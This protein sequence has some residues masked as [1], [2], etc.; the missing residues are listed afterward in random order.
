MH[1]T[2]HNKGWRSVAGILLFVCAA[3]VATQAQTGFTPGGTTISN[4]ASSTYSDGTDSYATSSNTVT[5]TV[6]NISGLTIT[7]DG[8]SNPAAVLGQTG[9][10][11]IFTVTNSGN[12]INQVRFGAGGASVVRT[13]PGAVTAAVIDVD[14]SNTINA[15]DTDIFGNASAVNSADVAQ[16]ATIKVIVRVSV[17]ANAAAGSVI[18]VQLGDASTGGPSYDNQVADS[19]AN[20]VRT[21]TAGSNPAEEARGDIS[22]TVQNDALL[23]LTLTAPAGPVAVGSDITYSWVLTNDGLRT[24]AAQTLGGN[25]GVFIVAPIPGRTALK[26]GQSFPAGTLYTTDPLTTAPLSATWTTTAP[27]D[28][29][30]VTRVALYAGASLAAGASSSS[31]SLLVTVQTGISVVLPI[32]EIGDAFAM[33]YVAAPITDQSGDA[34]ANAG[35]GNADFTQGDAIGS[36]DGDG[37]QQATAL[38]AVGGVLLGPSGQ[39]G[40][41]GPTDTNDDYTNRSVNT[42]IA[43]VAPGGSTTAAGTVVFTNTVQ[44]TGQANDTY[45]LT[46][47]SVPAGFTVEVS[48]NG[49]GTDYVTVSGGGSTT[50]AV[51]YGSTATILVRITAPSGNT[52]LTAYPTVIHAASLNTPATTNDTVD[53]L[54]TGY[55][56]L[57]KSQ[58]VANATGR[59]GATDPV[60]GATIAYVVGFDNVTSSGGTN[61]S[62]ISASSIVL[63]DPVPANTDFKAGSATS[64]PPAG[65]TVATTYSND[66]GAT[67]T[68]TPVSG[69]GSAPAG[70]DRTVTHVRFTLT[71]SMGPADIAG[72]AGFTV[73]IR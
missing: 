54:Y 60:P 65:I 37:V 38:S 16:G 29:T 69:A 13:G 72:D 68:Y 9:V 12:F 62:T 17:D 20:E 56:Q 6:S 71:G 55:L 48:A 8:G 58:T 4:Q 22:V 42:G 73:R 1:R 49:L 26:S 45:T 25:A 61:N 51:A 3:S 34:V 53:R 36:V 59:G 47:P 44:N 39:P 21:V 70:Y 28:L 43:T 50:L 15:G 41:V 14:N 46:A 23:R 66:G 63:T 57:T 24:A 67:F 2:L 11:F 18:N 10:D 31:I 32:K 40:A 64:N 5:V 52:V 7:P 35:D 27:G 19:S 33:N 30:T